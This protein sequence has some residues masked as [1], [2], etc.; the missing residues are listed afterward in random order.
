M[1]LADALRLYEEE[2]GTKTYK[3]VV[4]TSSTVHIFP[5]K[6]SADKFY[7]ECHESGVHAPSPMSEKE[8]LNTYFSEDSEY[9]VERHD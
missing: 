9:N 8:I 4:S 7:K 3:F 1:N 5:N 2:F 6:E